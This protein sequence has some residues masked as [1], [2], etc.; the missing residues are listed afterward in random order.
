[1]RIFKFFLLFLTPLCSFGQIDGENLFGTN[2]VIQIDLTFYQA[3]FWDSLVYNYENDLEMKADLS[4]TDN[5]GV[6]TFTDVNIQLKG[7]SSYGHPGNKKS[8]KIDFND[9]VPGQNY[10]GL[11]KL[12]F[13][14]CFKDPSFMREKLVF[15]AS[16]AAGVPAPRTNYANVSMNGTFWGFYAIEEQ[17]DDQFLDW[18]ILEDS[19]NLF[20]A[21]SNFGG[22]NTPADL[23]YYGSSA[24]DYTD[25]YDLKTNETAN[26]WTDFI[27]LLDFINNSSDADFENQFN[28]HFNQQ[29][30]LRSMAIDNLF[31]SLDTY[32]N[33]ARNYYLYHNM[34]SGQWE[35]I[36][37]D[38]NEGFGLYTGGP[39]SGNLEQLALN[40]HATDRPLLDRVMNS[41]VLYQAYLDEMCYLVNS[42]FTP[43]YMHARAEEIDLLI[44][45]HVANDVNKQYTTA[46]YTQNVEGN[47]TLSGGGPM[48]SQTV[49]GIKSFVTNK[50]AFIQTEL[51]CSS[52]VVS[53]DAVESI[54]VYP[55][56]F[57]DYIMLKSDTNQALEVRLMNQ[58]GQEI[59]VSKVYGDSMLQIPFYLEKGVY[60]LII[61]QENNQRVVKLLK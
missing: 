57:V 45:N 18:A 34:D 56:P 22:T 36:K 7:N 30:F 9:N 20:K 50:Y 12:N 2:Q 29:V 39:G 33:S 51:N 47:V 10:D 17:I 43:E 48:G 13:N 35:W 4:I 16:I 53:V 42:I 49:Y 61:N 1:M 31:S 54:E 15:D 59:F 41:S 3:S 23:K 19:G 38:G 21:G 60:Y 24:T 32:L 14:N 44:A 37:W 46:N 6:H 5:L 55:N 27:A 52:A 11:K 8:F 58:L 40:Y 26:D 25:R 28:Y